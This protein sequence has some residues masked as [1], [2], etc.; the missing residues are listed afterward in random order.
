MSDSIDFESEDEQGFGNSSR[1][2]RYLGKRRAR[3]PDDFEV[4]QV[5]DFDEHEIDDDEERVQA[6]S[7]T[8]GSSSSR[9]MHDPIDS[10]HHGDEEK[11][12]FRPVRPKKDKGISLDDEEEG[13]NPSWLLFH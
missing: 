11:P 12:T 7:R 9:R 1:R 2:Q 4:D 6:G 3:E 5:E 13:R 10:G 8:A